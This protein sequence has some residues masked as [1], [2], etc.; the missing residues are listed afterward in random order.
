MKMPSFRRLAQILIILLILLGSGGLKSHRSSLP[1]PLAG[2]TC[3]TPWS[4]PQARLKDHSLF[5]YQNYFYLVSIK[6]A[7]PAQ[8][9]R[10]EYTFAYARTKDFCTWENLGTVLTFGAAGAA[11][12]AYIWAPYVI[13]EG[14]LFFMFYTGVNQ[15]I[16]QSIMLAT[17]T[18][19]A[20]PKSWTKQGVVFRPNHEGMVYP[21]PESWSDARDPMVLRYNNRYFLYY[22]GQDKT[23]GIVGVA[24]AETLSGPWRDLGA[25]LQLPP[26]L[27]PESPFVV[28][29]DDFFYLYYNAAGAAANRLA[30]PQWQWSPSPF[31]PWQAPTKETLGWGHD[32][33][34]TGKAWLASYII[35]NGEAI[36]VKQ[37]D[38]DQTQF[39]PHPLLG[40][41]GFLPLVWNAR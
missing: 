11:D 33:F 29:K 32:F 10:G 19:P 35:G 13:Q 23:G 9:E 25:V 39:P 17:S 24:L 27:I 20:D 2:A 1:S 12:E 22:T 18:N 21:G 6:I 4:L 14:N 37:I 30:G 15:H 41:Q 38:W 8:D 7:L 28:A 36:G 16:S 5:A 40:Q 26:S 31:G 3:S 34:F